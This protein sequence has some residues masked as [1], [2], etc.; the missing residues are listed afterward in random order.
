MTVNPQIKRPATTAGRTS[1]AATQPH[2]YE[3]F[4]GRLLFFAL[5]LLGFGALMVYSSTSVIT[6]VLAKKKITEFHYF[7]KHLFTMALGFAVM[8]FF[9]RLRPGLLRKFSLPLLIFSFALLALV[10]VPGLGVS[11]GGARRWLRL[12]PSTFQPSELVKLAMVIFLARFISMRDYDP[13][14]FSYFLMPVC[15]MGLF[16]A[17]FLIQPDF[18]AAVSLF[19]LTMGMLFLSG[20]PFKY[21]AYLSALALPAVVAL[22]LAPYRLKR[23]MIFLDP[24]KDA[25]GGGFQL[26]QSFIALGSGGLTGVG[27]GKS[28]QKLDFL[29]EVHT[30]FI[31]SMVGEEL[32]FIVAAGVVSVFALLFWRGIEVARRAE[33]R[34]LYH[35]C[36]GLS[37]MLS[38]QALVNFCVVTGMLPTK[39]LPLPFISY[40]GSALLVNMAAVGILLNVS[41]PARDVR[42][43]PFGEALK[44]KKA[45]RAVYGEAP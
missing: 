25:K 37:L 5:L 24:W 12:W 30:D 23:I 45:K 11:A 26:V 6:P 34:F 21:M 31:F 9:Y 16:Q 39:G 17:V 10:F 44:K 8:F 18:G 20:T 42:G 2:F 7:Q 41:R 4:D 35:L 14:R 33:D 13:E 29:P 43:D 32:G 38:F 28:R 19:V 36:F 27:L 15:V 3:S 22:L 40:G 1:G